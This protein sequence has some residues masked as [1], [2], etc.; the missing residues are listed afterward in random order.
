MF[1]RVIVATDLSPASYA[2]VNC[3]GGLK[4]YGAKECLLLQCLSLQEVGSVALSYTTA[5]LEN[6]LNEQKEVL[7]KQGFAVETRIVP[8]L[9]TREINRVAEKEDY[10]LIVIGS[11]GHSMVR[12][13]LL[14]GVASAVLNQARKPVLVIRVEP[15]PGDANG[16]LR[17]ARCHR[18]CSGSRRRAQRRARR[19][20]CRPVRSGGCAARV[21]SSTGPARRPHT[22]PRD[23]T[24]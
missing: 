18:G 13:A 5:F 19:V 2:V 11:Q 17:A 14:G 1:S 16:C 8:R 22:G 12:E 21:G 20:A 10:S 24:R 7:E 4:A 3:V 6:S 15:V 9:A 23:R